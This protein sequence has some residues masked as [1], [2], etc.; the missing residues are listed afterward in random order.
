[1]RLG[2]SSRPIF[3]RGEDRDLGYLSTVKPIC[4]LNPSKLLLRH[5]SR[6]AVIISILL[7]LC[8]RQL[9]IAHTM[10]VIG[11][12]AQSISC[13]ACLRPLWV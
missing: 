7:S 9:Q 5:G 12:R 6:Y 10:L 3:T 2:A 4:V 11:P 1:V 8:S 13:I